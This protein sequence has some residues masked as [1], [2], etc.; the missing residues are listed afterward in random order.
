MELLAN[1]IVISVPFYF[2][3]KMRKNLFVVVSLLIIVA[4]IA[5]CTPTVIERSSN[6]RPADR[7]IAVN[8]TGSVYADPDVAYINIGVH[9]DNADPKAAL[10][11]NTTQAQA[12]IDALKEIGV[13]DKDIQTSNFNIYPSTQYG[14]NG[15]TQG[16][17]YMVDNTVYVTVRDLTKLDEMLE[18]VVSSGANNI[19]GI[20]FDI[21]DKDT[22]ASEARKN[23]VA[24]AQ[25]QAQDIADAAGVQLDELM[26]VNVYYSGTTYPQYEGKGGGG[27]YS[28]TLSVPISAGRMVIT[29]E[30]NMTYK[31]K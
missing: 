27:G 5:G 13:A 30:V 20:T 31:I 15:E 25:K 7:T 29:A 14:P 2:G 28:S 12:V 10:S 23:A 9:T 11:S 3:G 18:T 24:D 17:V 22:L 21:L 4:L 6:D 1:K 26:Y 16:T 19:N 8:G